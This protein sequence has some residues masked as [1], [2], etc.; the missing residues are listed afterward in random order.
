MRITTATATATTTNMSSIVL[1]G[2]LDSLSPRSLRPRFAKHLHSK[3][4]PRLSFEHA[5]QRFHS[6]WLDHH[7]YAWTIPVSTPLRTSSYN[8]LVFQL[9][10]GIGMV[11][12]VFV[13]HVLATGLARDADALGALTSWPTM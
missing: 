6:F 12:A 3:M 5:E 2:Q 10:N 4:Q 9:S 7:L 13:F 11:H 1:S 8:H